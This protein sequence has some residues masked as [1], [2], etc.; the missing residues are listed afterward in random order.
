MRKLFW[1]VVLLVGITLGVVSVWYFVNGESSGE[2]SRQEVALEQPRLISEPSKADS[3]HI[4]HGEVVDES[5]EESTEA[6]ELPEEPVAEDVDQPLQS[7]ANAAVDMVDTTGIAGQVVEA[8]VETVVQAS[9]V[10]VEAAV[11]ETTMEIIEAPPVADVVVEAA[12]PVDKMPAIAV[13]PFKVMGDAFNF[14]KD[15]SEERR[16][17]KECRSRWSPYH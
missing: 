1:I 13:L 9:S 3:S 17:G 4:P 12:S 5:I 11:A 10:V 7:N 14:N 8:A 2:S 6:E 16:V 15:R